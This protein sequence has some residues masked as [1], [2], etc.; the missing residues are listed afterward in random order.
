ME[1]TEECS[2]N[3]DV[4]T[5]SA[6]KYTSDTSMNVIAVATMSGAVTHTFVVNSDKLSELLQWD[7]GIYMGS[8]ATADQ[9]YNLFTSCWRPD[10]NYIF[11]KIIQGIIKSC[12]L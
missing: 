10:K 7:I 6:V 4:A 12:F 9:K 11:P 8:S 5:T 2:T 1:E 3:C